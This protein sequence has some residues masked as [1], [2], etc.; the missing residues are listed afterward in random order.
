MTKRV[1]WLTL[2]AIDEIPPTAAELLREAARLAAMT[3][4]ERLVR[5]MDREERAAASR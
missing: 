2:L 3:R 1:R 5:L 4:S